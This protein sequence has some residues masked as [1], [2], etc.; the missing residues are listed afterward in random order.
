MQTNQPDLTS[1]DPTPTLAELVLQQR[2]KD[3]AE[4]AAYFRAQEEKDHRE[5]QRLADRLEEI[6]GQYLWAAL[7]LLV[8][9]N[10]V[11]VPTNGAQAYDCEFALNEHRLRL[12]GRKGGSGMFGEGALIDIF[13]L[14]VEMGT[15]TDEESGEKHADYHELGRFENQV[16]FLRLMNNFID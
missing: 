15:S 14:Y 9:N 6:L 2:A 12:R 13:T 10:P 11:Q 5:R 16:E 8:T 7:Q 4:T 1:P 3:E